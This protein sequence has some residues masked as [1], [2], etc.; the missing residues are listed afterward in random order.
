MS[1]PLQRPRKYAIRSLW[2]A[3]IMAISV[4]PTISQP[5]NAAERGAYFYL[6]LGGS[7]SVGV[8]PTPTHPHG[9]P[10]DTGYANFFVAIEA[11]KGLNYQLTQLGCPG[12]TT[13]MA[14]YGGDRCYLAS[15]SQLKAATKFLSQNKGAYGVVTVDLGF[16]NVVHCLRHSS[17]PPSCIHQGLNQ[18][19][20]QLPVFLSTLQASAG[21]GVRFVGIGHY[22]PFLVS[23]MNVPAARSLWSIDALNQTL[24]DIYHAA[25]IPMVNVGNAFSMSETTPPPTPGHT[26]V[27]TNAKMVC[28]LT[29]MCAPAPYGPNL[30]PN[31]RGYKVIAEAMA[32]KMPAPP[33]VTTPMG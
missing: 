32:A 26:P 21:P 17:A 5:A 16:N 10:T 31:D 30:H 20:R 19:R 24:F 2:A 11:S 29:W 1:S 33:L 3:A 12:E 15:E 25:R 28:E 6:D 4:A 18:V 23:T 13:A 14:L 27:P 7:G 22:D 8:Q 9:Q